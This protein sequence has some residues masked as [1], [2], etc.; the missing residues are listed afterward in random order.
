MI[1]VELDN[2]SL[3]EI[4][5]SGQCF[6][7]YE[8]AENTY[9]LIAGDKY[10]KM[11]QEGSIVNFYC[12][13]ME[14]ICYWVPYFDIDADYSSYIAKI[15]PRDTYLVEAAECGSG[16]RILQQDLW[17]MIITF[18]ISQQNNISRIRGCVERLCE[19]YGEKKTSEEKEYYA[20][21]TPEQLA[22]I[23]RESSKTGNGIPGTLY[24]GDDPEYSGRRDF[25]GANLPLPLLP[26]CEAGTYE[27][28]RRGG[29]GSRLH[30]PF[31]TA[32]YGCIS[33]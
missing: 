28:E 13:D 22:G 16:I 5:Q 3:K 17:E 1:T 14:F 29:K 23:R 31:C 6:R 4:C 21:P 15:N 33:G 2:F 24:C 19:A 18:L 12:S 26:P 25:T 9:E 27:T 8:T 20:F 7:M 32:S 11:T 30:L 10:L